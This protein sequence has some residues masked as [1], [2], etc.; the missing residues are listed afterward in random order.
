MLPKI[1]LNIESK[2]YRPQF[3]DWLAGGWIGC[4][5][6]TYYW[7]AQDSNYGFGWEVEPISEEDWRDFNEEELNEIMMTIEKYLYKHKAEY[8]IEA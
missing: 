6:K 7:S 4:K 5:G 1:V 2:Y 8:L 3:D